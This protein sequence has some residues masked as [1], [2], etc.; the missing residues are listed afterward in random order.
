VSASLALLA[1]A[2]LAWPS[3]ATARRQRLR[4]LLPTDT[5]ARPRRTPSGP[6]GVRRRWTEAVAGGLAT[7]LLLGGGPPAG[8]LAA[9]VVAGLERLHRSAGAAAG[10]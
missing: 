10:P 3:V 7:Y 8:L 6:P 5:S 1:A 4:A 2:L 9:G